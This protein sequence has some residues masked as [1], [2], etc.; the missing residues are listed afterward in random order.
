M[1]QS[2]TD[3]ADNRMRRIDIRVTPEEQAR[4]DERAGKA[5]LSR[6]EFIRNAAMTD[7]VTVKQAKHPNFQLIHELNKIG[8]NLNQVVHAAHIRGKLPKSL[9][10]LCEEI[11]RLVVK[12]AEEV[13]AE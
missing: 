2:R 1:A 11:E 12:A 4:I 8:V 6:S 10:A 9:P 13:D 7:K 3:V 5:G